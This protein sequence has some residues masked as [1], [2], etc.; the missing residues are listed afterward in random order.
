[1]SERIGLATGYDPALS[2]RD[3]AEA[4]AEVERRGWEIAF[5]SE[6]V[7]LMRDSVTALAAFAAATS[8]ITLGCT[9]VVRLRSPVLMA[10]TIASLDELSGGRLVV[11]PGAAT[12]VHAATHALDPLDPPVALREWIEAIRLL[13]GGEPVSYAGRVVKLEGVALGW[14]PIRPRVPLWIAATSATGLRLAGEI[15]DG[16]LLNTVA[17]PEYAANAVAIVRRAVEA[18][19]RDW[20]RF[21][22][23]QLIN[24]S[25]EDDADRAVDAVRWEVATKFLPGKFASQAG[26]RLRVGEPHI[27]PAIVPGLERAHVSGGPEALA[28]AL[29]ASMVRGLT[30]A[31]RPDEVRAR[32][33]RYRDAGVKLPIVR[34]AAAHQTRRVIE[35]LSPR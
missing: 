19:G 21:E 2:V 1:V 26:P 17:S 10:Q 24:T 35:L 5:F 15:G 34:P 6:T 32:V 12:R 16:V 29:P 30:A 25:V 33:Q 3:F 27:D 14:K 7:A 20:D 9:Q 22:V 18:A 31:G 8:R 4:V 23:A 13:L 11:C 28:R